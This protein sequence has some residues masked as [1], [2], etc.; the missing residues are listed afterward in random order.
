MP[1]GMAAPACVRVRMACS[2]LAGRT[3]RTVVEDCQDV[4]QP[5]GNAFVVHGLG[6]GLDHAYTSFIKGVPRWVRP[7][8]RG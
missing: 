7:T 8:G 3:P 5:S 6:G 2:V 4:C 1:G